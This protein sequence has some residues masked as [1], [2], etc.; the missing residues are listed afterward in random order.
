MA[1]HA[2]AR[3]GW[4]LGEAQERRARSEWRNITDCAGA[5]DAGASKGGRL[6]PPVVRKAG[7]ISGL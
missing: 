2:K 6:Y 5:G 7:W 3:E 1:D 4:K